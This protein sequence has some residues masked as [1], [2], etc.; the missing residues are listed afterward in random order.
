MVYA[1]RDEEEE[2]LLALVKPGVIGELI[3]HITREMQ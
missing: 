3:T 2:T 1:G